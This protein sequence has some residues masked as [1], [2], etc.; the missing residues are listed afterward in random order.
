MIRRSVPLFKS[1]ERPWL[2]V[3]TCWK[4][5]WRHEPALCG[6][7]TGVR[8]PLAVDGVAVMGLL[9]VSNSLLAQKISRFFKRKTRGSFSRN[10][11]IDDG[12]L[13][14]RSNR[15]WHVC[16]QQSAVDLFWLVATS[17]PLYVL[18]LLFYSFTVRTT[19]C[20]WAQAGQRRHAVLHLDTR[21]LRR[22]RR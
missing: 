8:H 22:K 3:L 4:M 18:E 12:R 17:T 10:I 9:P 20:R 14:R 11:H 5:A 7:I 6:L 15:T 21:V 2:G 13:Q 1:P 16:G 19:Q